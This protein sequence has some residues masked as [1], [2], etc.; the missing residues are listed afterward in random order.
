MSAVMNFDG[1]A[2]SSGRSSFTD[3]VMAYGVAGA[4]GWAELI[5]A[6]DAI[7]SVAIGE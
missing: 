1:C 2:L 7:A 3:S 5:A 4:V 6:A